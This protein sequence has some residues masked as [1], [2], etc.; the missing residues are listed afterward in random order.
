MVDKKYPRKDF[1]DF[2]E[3]ELLLKGKGLSQMLSKQQCGNCRFSL[4]TL[5]YASRPMMTMLE[6]RECEGC[7]HVE[8]KYYYLH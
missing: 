1:F 5:S 8:E 3:V 7:G 6:E 2:D 4:A